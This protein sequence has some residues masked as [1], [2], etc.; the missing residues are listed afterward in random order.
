MTKVCTKDIYHNYL[1][2]D[3]PFEWRA[4]TAKLM[5]SDKRLAAVAVSEFQF[6]RSEY[7][8]RERL[9]LPP[10]LTPDPQYNNSMLGGSCWVL[11]KLD[12][13][14]HHALRCSDIIQLELDDISRNHMVM[15]ASMFA[16][17][18]VKSW[19]S[20]LYFLCLNCQYKHTALFWRLIQPV[21]TPP[22][23]SFPPCF[24]YLLYISRP[25]LRKIFKYQY[26]SAPSQG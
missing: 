1:I 18:T 2:G 23:W 22:C 15:P 17:K 6:Q 5:S 3:D 24:Q 16:T 12:L 13:Q 21:A 14:F 4:T 19:N 10:R 9:R 20:T 26:R 11:G 25:S 7:R 8:L